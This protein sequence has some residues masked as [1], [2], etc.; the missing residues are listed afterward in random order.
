[1][2]TTAAQRAQRLATLEKLV[3]HDFALERAILRDLEDCLNEIERQHG[4]LECYGD[5]EQL[6]RSFHELY[7]ALAPDYGYETRPETA[8]PWEKVPQQNKALMLA[9][10]MAIGGAATQCLAAEAQLRKEQT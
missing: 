4:A 9:V 6:A 7:E 5:A 1:M 10:A 8:V 2:R 3:E